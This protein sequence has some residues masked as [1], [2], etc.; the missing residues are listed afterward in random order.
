MTILIQSTNQNIK[1]NNPILLV[2]IKRAENQQ[3]LKRRKNV[4]TN[5]EIKF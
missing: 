1:R 5:K 4:G 3:L 2:N